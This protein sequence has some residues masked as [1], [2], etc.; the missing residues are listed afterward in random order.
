MTGPPF[1]WPACPCPRPRPA[2]S[3]SLSPFLALGRR[4]LALALVSAIV[5]TH[6]EHRC[7]NHH[8]HR[9]PNGQPL[10]GQPTFRL[11]IRHLQ[12]RV[13]R[14]QR[15]LRRI[16]ILEFVPRPATEK[17]IHAGIIRHRSRGRRYTKLHATAW[18]LR[19]TPGVLLFY[20]DRL[21]TARAVKFDH[22]NSLLAVSRKTRLKWFA[23]GVILPLTIA[24]NKDSPR[25]K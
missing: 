21:G 10:Y 8:H 4:T 24:Q 16:T 20:R 23:S 14:G 22:G 13:V 18:A 7:Q 3:T 11:R 12:R 9:C 25:Q 1:P 19:A 15:L 6:Q 2:P 5:A 17:R